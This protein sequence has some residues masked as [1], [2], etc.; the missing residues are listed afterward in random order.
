M[1]RDGEREEGTEKSGEAP[2]LHLHISRM[3]DQSEG[4]ISVG[5]ALAV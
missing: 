5:L 2:A 3:H 1:G 4:R